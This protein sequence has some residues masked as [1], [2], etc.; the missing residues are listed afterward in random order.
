MI[1]DA[2]IILLDNRWDFD[3]ETRDRLGDLQWEMLDKAL[4]R[5]AMV[6]FIMAGIQIVN[7]HILPLERFEW[8]NKKRLQDLLYKHRLSNVIFLSGDVHFSQ[9]SVP[10]CG[11]FTP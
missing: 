11:L 7:D 5:E 4:G 6:T 1:G 3:Y 9:I 2:H 8:K 10:P